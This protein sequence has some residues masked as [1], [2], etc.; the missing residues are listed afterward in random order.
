MYSIIKKKIVMTNGQHK[1]GKLAKTLE[2]QTAKIPSDIY[3]WT[4]VGTM[5][6]SLSLLLAKKKHLSLFF[7]QWAPSL[8]VIGLY[9][10]LVKTDG[11]DLEDKQEKT[12]RRT[13]SSLS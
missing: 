12:H 10:K 5:V 3:L 8:L 9:N 1:E 2:S 7:G 4:A 13:A 6:A 11:H